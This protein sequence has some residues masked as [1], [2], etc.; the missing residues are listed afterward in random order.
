MPAGVP[1]L[2]IFS[3]K[4]MALATILVVTLV[5]LLAWKINE[6]I[7]G[8]PLFTLGL[9]SLCLGGLTGIARIVISGNAII[10]AFN[11]FVV[12]GMIIISQSIRI[13][14]G[15][16]P[17]P[18]TAVLGFAA[19]VAVFQYWWLFVH[20]NFG[21]RVGVISAAMA[22]LSLDAAVSMFRRVVPAERV[23]YWPTG[24]AFAFAA[25]CLAL[26]SASALFGTYGATVWA[27]V[28]VELAFT[29]CASAACVWCVFGML[30]A[31]KA[32]LTREA[33][34]MALIDPLTNLPNRRSFWE[35]LL[36]AEEHA[37]T[38]DRKF[39]LIYLDLDEFKQI[40]DVLG[41]DA[42]DDLLRAIGAAM[43]GMLRSGDCLAR[44]GG[45]EFVVLVGDV[46]NQ[47]DVESLAQRLKATVERGGSPVRISC[48]TAT[49]PSDGVSAHDAMRQ[50]DAAMYRA[51]QQSRID[52]KS[53]PTGVLD[54]PG[55]LMTPHASHQNGSILTHPS[56]RRRRRSDQSNPARQSPKTRFRASSIWPTVQPA[57]ASHRTSWSRPL[58]WIGY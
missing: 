26:R 16:P 55:N 22:L 43:A 9:L 8:M 39:G 11:V 3:V 32:Q 53:G 7:A 18:R 25:S 4:A 35:R 46:Q 57:P 52:K 27:P 20:S 14:R 31:S 30:F 51:K 56:Y 33:E 38:S 2:D 50:A 42:G 29:F 28:P 41:H 37:Q 21:M 58:S 36:D 48:G 10:V 17:L 47:D 45:D 49:F 13:F 54:Q 24:C 6:R 44:I 40:N 12:G 1:S 19:G 5:T 23:V 34:K 15:L